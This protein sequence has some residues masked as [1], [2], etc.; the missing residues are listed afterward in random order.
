[1]ALRP[2]NILVRPCYSDFLGNRLFVHQDQRGIDPKQ[3]ALWLWME[4]LIELKKRIEAYGW[5]INTW[6]M[7]PV[8]SADVIIVQDLPPDRAEM[9]AVRK[10]APKAKF[11]LL[12][13]ETPLSRPQA[14]DPVNHALFDAV[15]T[16]DRRLV[17][18]K[19]Y[20]YCAV[21]LG[22][23]PPAVAQ[24]PFA[25]RQPLVMTNTNRWIGWLAYR[26]PGLA[27]LPFVGPALSG[28]HVQP[29]A[30]LRQNKG[31]QYSHRRQLARLADREFPGVLDVYGYGW[32]GEPTSWAHRF[33]RHRPF[34]C[35]RG[36]VKDKL[37]LTAK[38][39][40]AVTFENQISNCGYISEKIY[41]VLYSGAVPIYLGDQNIT[42]VV[43]A[44]CF[45]DARIFKGDDRALLRFVS[46]CD[47]PT[48][49]QYYDAGRRFL[50]SSAVESV[51][52]PA[53]AK[54]VVTA[55]EAVTGICVPMI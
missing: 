23:P 25:Q 26:N 11:V 42:D 14:W 21:S 48:W 30:L 38:Y 50:A 55:I 33:V 12:I 28:W 6:D 8:E 9:D 1:M 47:E 45:V 35:G 20:F 37:A 34:N 52:P 36:F 3:A 51:Q 24:I 16:Y 49:T 7:Q 19:R 4:P 15:L 27:G 46:S 53:F 5:Q 18:N 22:Y 40:F 31:E 29:M 32:M 2:L 43:P 17:D 54:S 44:D 13:W 39:R 10:R 41:D